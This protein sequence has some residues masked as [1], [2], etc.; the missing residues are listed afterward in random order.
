[1]KAVGVTAGHWFKDSGAVCSGIQENMLNLRVQG[2]IITTL[3]EA[4][5]YVVTATGELANKVQQLNTYPLLA[6]I[7]VHFNA[8]E[9]TTVKGAE[10]VYMDNSSGGKQLATLIYN[11]LCQLPFIDKNRKVLSMSELGRGDLF[12]LKST[13][14]Y[15][16]IV[17]PLW[18]SNPL[19][20]EKLT[21]ENMDKIGEAIAQGILGYIA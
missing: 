20:R 7:E 4:G 5:V 19:D 9:N 8:V 11:S 21:H 17:E 1:M 3:A 14:A 13:K 10:A 18:L 12:F 2:K 15:A 16:A 6:A